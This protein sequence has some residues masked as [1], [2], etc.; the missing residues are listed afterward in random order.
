MADDPDIHAMSGDAF[1]LMW[2]LKLTLHPIGVGVVYPSA[3][4]DRLHCDVETLERLFQELEAPK[5]GST[6]GWIMRD[7]TTVWLINALACEP[8][9]SSVTP[10]HRKFVQKGLAKLSDRSPVVRAFRAYYAEWFDEPL[11][12]EHEDSRKGSGTHAEGM[13]KGSERVGDPK[14][15]QSEAVSSQGEAVNLDQSTAGEP[16]DGP[17]RTSSAQGNTTATASPAAQQKLEPPRVD[18]GAPLEPLPRHAQQLLRQCYGIRAG[19]ALTELTDRQKQVGRDLRAT[20]GNDGALLERGL[21]VQ[22]WDAAH[23]DTACK[24]VL[25]NGVKKSD[26]A[27]RLVLLELRKTYQERRAAAEKATRD[28]TPARGKRGD[29]PRAIASLLSTPHAVADLE[30]ARR[31]LAE[32]PPATHDAI[33]SEVNRK[34]PPGRSPAARNVLVDD[35]TLLAWRHREPTRATA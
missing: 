16:D 30:E 20:L 29:S 2:M 6:S 5:P 24:T 35:A 23:L 34:C 13:A 8:T 33:E 28:E 9:M 25:D 1:K 21:Y 3:M 12:G 14:Q 32:Q 11:E 26:A 27:I 17:A 18:Q 4:C 7:R 22:A 31:W 19:V 15:L 10:N